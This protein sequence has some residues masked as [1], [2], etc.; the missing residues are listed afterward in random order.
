MATQPLVTVKKA[1]G[2][3]VKMTLDELAVYKKS[4]AAATAPV[5][6]A[7]QVPKPAAVPTPAPPKAAS[8][9]LPK[10]PAPSKPAITPAPAPEEKSEDIDI[11]ATSKILESL[12]PSEPLLEQ[13]ET[14]VSIEDA[15]KKIES[16][17]EK[18]APK[19]AKI[20]EEHANLPA[21][22]SPHE[23]ATVTPVKDFFKAEAKAKAQHADW[24][25]GDHASLL[26]E[27]TELQAPAQ[28]GAHILTTS[29]V[30]E[31]LEQVPGSVDPAMHDR[32]E[33]L[34]RSHLSGVRND[35]Q[36][37]EY[38]RKAVDKGGIGVS[39]KDLTHLM[40]VIHEVYGI[41]HEKMAA[42]GKEAPPMKPR[43]TPPSLPNMPAEPA[44]SDWMSQYKQPDSAPAGKPVMHDVVAA[45]EV[46]TTTGPV[47]ELAQFSPVD[48]H[49]L[50]DAGVLLK[51]DLS[52]QLQSL[53]EDAFTMYLDGRAAWFRSPLYSLYMHTILT[54]LNESKPLEDALVTE[55]RD[56][57]LTKEQINQIG[58]VSAMLRF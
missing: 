4:Q 16:I 30:V 18:P 54:A 44:G 1:D 47:Q 6:A 9:E 40:K 11:E 34:I 46:R 19:P 39:E 7:P 5:S 58:A 45:Q 33:K 42:L 38:L 27:S 56:D 55:R 57:A 35:Q 52:R 32:L 50:E 31:V 23:L 20:L 8:P 48:L 51:D 26:E 29:H 22:E 3:S 14:L 13:E 12:V 43:I 49:R 28:A 2:T 21:V 15:L 25:E 24:E 37:E 36:L 41:H 10:A 53:K 17:E